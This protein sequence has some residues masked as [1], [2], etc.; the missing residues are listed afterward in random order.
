MPTEQEI[1]N[2]V[3]KA[4]KGHCDGCDVRLTVGGADCSLMKKIEAFT[5]LSF[6]CAHFH[7]TDRKRKKEEPIWM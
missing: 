5:L 7:I 1:W 4:K 6:F 2:F 3:N